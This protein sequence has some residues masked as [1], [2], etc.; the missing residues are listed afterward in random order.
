MNHRGDVYTHP[1][2]HTEED[3]PVEEEDTESEDNT[4]QALKVK[5]KKIGF[6]DR[7]VPRTNIM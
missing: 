1:H 4:E 2:I 3:E 6:H 7:K 5:K